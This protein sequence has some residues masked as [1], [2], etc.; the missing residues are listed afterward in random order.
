MTKQAKST[1]T[2]VAMVFGQGAKRDLFQVLHIPRE[3][4]FV[5]VEREKLILRTIHLQH[6]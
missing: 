3:T 5:N 4:D 2:F 6:S 1:R